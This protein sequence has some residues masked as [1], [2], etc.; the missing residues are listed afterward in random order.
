MGEESVEKVGLIRLMS[1]LGL[2]TGGL[3]RLGI[4]TRLA[5]YRRGWLPVRRL[6]FPVIS[7]GNLTVGGSGK[8]PH[9]ALIAAY[10][11]KKGIRVVVLSRGYGGE[12]SRSG[13]V[14]ATDREIVGTVEEG[15][16]EPYWLAEHLPGVPVIIGRNRYRS[17]MLAFERFQAQLAVLDDGYQHL[18]LARDMNI[19]LLPAHRPFGEGGLLPIGTLREPESQIKRADLLVITQAEMVPEENRPALQTR[20]QAR[21]PQTPLFFSSHEPRS[22]WRF[23][24]REPQP[25]SWLKDKRVLAFC[26]LARPESFAHSLRAAGAEVARLVPFRDHYGYREKD[27]RR[28][29]RQAEEAE[30]AA[31]VTTEKDALK[32]PDWLGG[33]PLFVLQIEVVLPDPE[34]WRRMDSV[35]PVFSVPSR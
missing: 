3:Y 8:T 34:F 25:L 27:L 11:K 23:P 35:L 20:I 6:P 28:L 4:S 17:G 14:I 32:L 29:A 1:W 2:L 22:L 15:G 18:A 26:G 5:L 31:V 9:V 21:R 30:A 16:E 19:L 7:V 33:P 13:A 12:K 24:G 10:F